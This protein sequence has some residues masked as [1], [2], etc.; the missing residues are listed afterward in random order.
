MTTWA[1]QVDTRQVTTAT[2][3][4]ERSGPAIRAVLDEVSPDECVQFEAEFAHALARAGAEFDLAPAEAVLDRW[5]GIA[6]IRANPLSEQEQEQA[7]LARAREG[8]F[9]GLWERDEAGNWV[10]L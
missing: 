5:W 1:G 8:V 7:Q 10:Q 3:R 4:I 6:V 2:T 9:D